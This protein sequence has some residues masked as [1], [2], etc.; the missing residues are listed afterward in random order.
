MV[1]RIIYILFLLLLPIGLAAR[2]IVVIGQVFSADSVPLPS[3][4]VWFSGT[5][6]GCTT[7][8]EG[9]FYLR[10]NEPQR[11]LIVSV[12]GYKRKTVKLDYG[13]DQ[14][15]TIFLDE[16][17]WPIDAMVVR[18]DNRQ[19]LYIINNVYSH[20][21]ENML[22][23]Y[24]LKTSDV[25]LTD[26][27]NHTLQR[28]LFN[29]LN[30]GIIDRKDSTYSLPAYH[31]LKDSSHYIEENF[32]PVFERDHWRDIINGFSPKVNLYSPYIT[33]LNYNFLS[34]ISRSPG[35]YYDIYLLDSTSTT[36]SK[37]Y[38]LKFRP[39]STNGLYL[40][41]TI[42]VDSATWRITASDIKTSPYT[43][44]NI[45]NSF[46]FSHND[47]TSSQALSLGIN[48]LKIENLNLLG[49]MLF[50][51][52]QLDNSPVVKSEIIAENENRTSRIDSIKGSKLVNV[53]RYTFDLLLAQ[54]VHAGPID[55]GPVFSMFHYNKRDGA[56]PI[57]SLR[58][59]QR[60]LNNVSFGGYFGYAHTARQM[61]YGGNIKV[62][63][64]NLRNHFTLS[65]DH[66]S[67]KYGFDDSHIFDE[68]N[69]NDAD[70]LMNSISQITL[71]AN[72][73]FRTIIAATYSYEAKIRK[74]N[75]RFFTRLYLQR[76][77]CDMSQLQNPTDQHS[78]LDNT[79][80]QVDF[81]LAWQQR[82]YDTYFQRYYFNSKY[83]VVH[84]YGEAGYYSLTN[85]QAH[86]GKWGVYAEQKLPVGFGKLTWTARTSGVI[87]AVPFHLLDYIR[88]SRGSL[89]MVND[90]TLLNQMEFASDLLLTAT[91]RYQTHG[92][93]FG[94]IPEV[95]RLGIREDL[96]FNIG[97]GWLA[98]S[99][100][101]VM[102]LYGTTQP[103]GNLPYIECGFGLSN[104]L[105][106]FKIQF[107]FRCTYRENPDAQLF[108]VKWAAE[109]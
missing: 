82:S 59:N 88:T 58:T 39:K 100:S 68:N 74:T 41:G 55:I 35:V 21:R 63:T 79:G 103:W 75:F 85:A 30:S 99:H 51:H 76:V 90:F 77:S 1:K 38:R 96:Y 105:S 67:Y 18:P 15:V 40:Q 13:R 9:F 6:N 7:N 37:T 86:F 14:M 23:P 93:I 95:K 5:K 27:P 50:E 25:N 97:Y 108:N 2:D 104:L 48:P 71:P 34:P 106:F 69:V 26:I 80:L 61:L 32:L 65:Y 89:N 54:H 10:S 101:S 57:I 64:N 83:P 28:R 72:N 53:V 73:D 46:T 87:G 107:M 17:F 22:K 11:T 29:D 4:N 49:A 8:E 44:I 56:T 66:K 62:R 24:I 16:E 36:T 45:L 3:A 109:F 20:H 42:D 31:S 52:S 47:S 102:P 12:V 60:C 91:L 81:R 19:A 84:I 94:Y 43:N 78:N 33:I 98:N 70:N 92:Y